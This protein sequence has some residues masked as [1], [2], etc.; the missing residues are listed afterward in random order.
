MPF[1][2]VPSVSLILPVYNTFL[3]I[4]DCLNSLVEQTFLNL[5]IILVDDGST[6]G[7][8][9]KCDLWAKVDPRVRTVHIANSGVSEARNTGLKIATGDYILFI[10][11]DD[12]LLDNSSITKIVETAIEHAADVLVFTYQRID[13]NGNTIDGYS[14]RRFP[15]GKISADEACKR[16]FSY[17]FGNYIWRLLIK[18]QLFNESKIQFPK[19]STYEDLVVVTEIL[20]NSQNIFFLREAL[21]GYRIR[22]GQQTSSFPLDTLYDML[23]AL[24]ERQVFLS[25]HRHSLIP[26]GKACLYDEYVNLYR[27][28]LYVLPSFSRDIFLRK[29]ENEIEIK[30]VFFAPYIKASARPQL[31]FM[32]IRIMPFLGHLIDRIKRIIRRT[33]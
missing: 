10:D 1:K 9:E 31:L 26:Y 3:F 8:S 21:Y 32:K 7:S 17:D 13:E 25:N 4:D 12:V 2:S 15:S 6:D 30:S 22:V 20:I 16:L 24:R 14:E 5:E 27:K 28:A 18:R 33:Y 23:S 19:Y 29:I 11:P